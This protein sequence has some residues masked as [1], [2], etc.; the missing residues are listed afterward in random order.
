ME[1]RVLTTE[2]RGKSLFSF[3]FKKETS[4]KTHQ[5]ELSPR[6][7]S[8]LA[9]SYSA[10]GQLLK[11]TCLQQSRPAQPRET[12]TSRK[13][14]AVWRSLSGSPRGHFLS[15]TAGPAPWAQPHCRTPGSSSSAHLGCNK[16]ARRTRMLP[17]QGEDHTVTC[18]C[19]YLHCES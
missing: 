3:F 19:S 13:Q 16:K 1:P 18:N 11:P 5:L 8:A 12:N 15:C 2:S 7:L 17:P 4:I 14:C 9:C 6:S 10:Q